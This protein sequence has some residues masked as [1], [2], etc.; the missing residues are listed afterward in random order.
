MKK[1]KSFK[2]TYTT[3]D[4]AGMESFH[5]NYDKAV[6][7][8]ARQFGKSY[9]IIIAGQEIKTSHLRKPYSRIGRLQDWSSRAPLKSG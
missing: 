1:E 9:P 6:Q 8:V 3:S 5:Q 2:V 4:P 7:H